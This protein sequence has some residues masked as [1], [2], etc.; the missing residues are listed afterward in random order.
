MIDVDADK[1]DR[2]LWKF[3]LPE[4]FTG[5]YGAWYGGTFE[6]TLS[7]FSG[8]YSGAND[9]WVED[10][11][12]PLNLVEIY[13]ESCDLYKGVTIAYPLST[14]PKFTGSTT[15]YAL[16][17]TETSG[18]VKDP[19]NTLYEWSVPSRCSLIE[20]LSRITSVRILGDFTNWYEGISI[21]NVRYVAAPAKGR[22]QIPVC[23]Q[24]SKCSC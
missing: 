12:H 18:W 24:D 21:D 15:H 1:N 8:D 16:Q 9:H 4:K 17:M 2:K 3:V 23:T 5:W 19:Q 14:G 6:F 13:C 20:V 7:S 11:F 22:Y 10:K